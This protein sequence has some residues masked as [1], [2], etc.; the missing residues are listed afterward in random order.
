MKNGNG[1]LRARLT[2]IT[3]VSGLLVYAGAAGAQG[4]Q[5]ATNLTLKAELT[6]RETYDDNV[7]I[8]DTAPDPTLTPPAGYTIS[9]PKKESLV[10]SVI[11]GLTLNYRPCAAF[12]A[13]V[14]YAPEA[15]WYHSA[16]SEDYVAHRAAINFSGKIN[17]ITYDWVNSMTWIDGSDLGPVTMRPGDC[18]AIGG[19]PLRDRRDGVAFR[20]GLKVTIPIGK[21]FIRPVVNAYV[22]DF[23]IEQRAS[24][25]GYVYDYFIDRWDVGGGLDVGYEAFA[26]TK[27]VA[28]YRYGHQEQGPRSGMASPYSND[29]QRFLLGVEGAP[30]PWLK[31]AVLAGP[32]VRNWRNSPPAAFD[33][34]EVLWFV[35]ATATIL[36]TQADTLTLR[37]T[38]FEQPAFTSHSVYEDIR[39]DL[40]WRHRFTDKF[41][42][43][44]GLTLYI[45]DWQSPA[46]REDWIYTPSVLASYTFSPHL[47]ADVM[48]S[49]DNAKNQVTPVAGTSTQFADGR[50]FTRN[51]ISLTL[52][53]TF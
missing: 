45:G 24:G 27:L 17:E 29:Y 36:P 16:H 31:L 33:E 13:T 6:I 53:Y 4:W 38:R 19:I 49:Y 37:A 32:D 51:L 44:A 40:T 25:A 41:V 39:Y 9:V 47:T 46:K 2:R 28:G 15:T 3:L 42:A 23:Q 48:W 30:A 43:G 50:E 20:N 1:T 11:P 14:S 10:T 34:D 22:H 18:R 12:V 26:R 8:L 21:W 5:L 35:D 52:K 7:F